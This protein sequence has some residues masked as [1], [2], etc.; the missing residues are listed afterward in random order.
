MAWTLLA[1]G[2]C[3]YIPQSSG[4]KVPLIA[5]FVFVFAGSSPTLHMNN[6]LISL[7]LSFLLARRRPCALHVLRGSLPLDPPR[8]WNVRLLLPTSSRVYVAKLLCRSWAVAQC[9]G[10]AAALSITFPRMLGNLG[11]TGGMSNCNSTSFNPLTYSSRFSF[12]LLCW[13][14]RCCFH[15]DILPRAWYV[16]HSHYVY[17]T[18]SQTNL[19]PFHVETKQRTLE[20]LDYVFAVP[21]SRHMSY[22]ANTWLPYFIK[23]WVFFRKDAKLTPLYN[24]DE[25]ESITVFEKGVGH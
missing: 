24:F 11:P 2:F 14:E 23:R 17:F 20:E 1:A 16:S 4:A 13:P 22:Q 21:T 8:A 6:D 9:L 19:S 7:Y 18:T 25:V 5:F 12:R 15:H 3:F 10:W